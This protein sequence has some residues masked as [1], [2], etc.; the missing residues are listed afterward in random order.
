MP[1]GNKPL[2]EPLWIYCGIHLRLI[3]HD[4]HKTSIHIMS[5]KNILVNPL[6]Y[7]SWAI[8]ITAPDAIN[9]VGLDYLAPDYS[10][11][12]RLHCR[13][14]TIILCIN[15]NRGDEMDLV[16]FTMNLKFHFGVD[17]Y[18]C[19]GAKIVITVIVRPKWQST[20]M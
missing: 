19:C 11:G 17:I 18:V 6:P 15:M 2:P 20:G 4:V 3:S 13:Y 12:S 5:L 16:L 14:I 9:A 7:L 10:G 8:Y 1:D